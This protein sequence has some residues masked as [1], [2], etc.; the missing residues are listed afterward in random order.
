MEAIEQVKELFE[1]YKRLYPKSEDKFV[2]SADNLKK[3]AY[4]IKQAEQRQLMHFKLY[5]FPEA[6]E[7]VLKFV[8]SRAVFSF[9]QFPKET[10]NKYMQ[11]AAIFSF[12]KVYAVGSRVNGDY[13]CQ[14]ASNKEKEMRR[15]LCKKNVLQSD[16]DF[17][18]DFKKQDDL[19]K[20]KALIPSGFDLVINHPETERKILVPMWNFSKIPVSRHDE[21]LRLIEQKQ[22]VKLMAIHNEY[23]LS[24][25]V[26]CCDSKP[27]M[28]WFKWAAENNIFNGKQIERLD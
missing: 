12:R 22:W 13:I 5:Q 8:D 15:I 19:K 6:T 21:I 20:I 14:D 7:E 2:F 23:Q 16:Y 1:K 26:F 3:W 25:H 9:Y 11:I 17:V 28:K 27:A 24:D 18:L 10:Q 4:L